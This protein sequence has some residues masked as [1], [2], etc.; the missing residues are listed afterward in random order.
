MAYED[1]IKDIIEEAQDKYDDE[2]YEKYPG[3]IVAPLN[4]AQEEGLGEMVD[5]DQL[6]QNQD[7]YN[8]IAQDTVGGIGQSQDMADSIF[9]KTGQDV[10]SETQSMI[11]KYYNSDLVQKQ[12]DAAS[13]Q[14]WEDYEAMATQSEW[15]DVATG[16]SGS[17]RA[18]VQSATA[19]GEAQEAVA[20]SNAAIQG[21]AYNQASQMAGQQQMANAQ[22]QMAAAGLTLQGGQVGMNAMDQAGMAAQQS[23]MNQMDAGGMWQQQGQAQMTSDYMQWMQQQNY[24]WNQLNQY[25]NL[26]TALLNLLNSKVTISVV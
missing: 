8:Q 15:N 12:Q 9:N 24:G 2:S 18:G 26:Y 1:Q 17:S 23:M 3:E 10:A 14:I 4:P 22:Q 25:A 16:G 5:S 13:G 7:M 21:N 6:N 19:Y 20:Q 11:D